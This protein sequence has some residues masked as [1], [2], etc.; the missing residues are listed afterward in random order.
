MRV[1]VTGATGFVGSN[2]ALALEDAGHDVVAIGSRG[3]QE[4]PEFRGKLLYRHGADLPLSEVG[5]VDILFHQGANADTSVKDRDQMFRDNLETSKVLF[6]Y[7]SSHGVKHIVYASSTAVYGNLPTPYKESGPIVPLNP[8]AE[9][10]AALD[11]YAMEFASEYPDIR[12]IGLRYC[13]VYGPR[14][15]HKGKMA[16][17]IRQLAMQMREGNPRIFK[18]GEQERE[19]IY[20]KDV[21]QA[22][23]LALNASESAVLNCSSGDPT[24]FNEL[25]RILNEV[26]GLERVPEYIDNPFEATYQNHI[27]CDISR[28]NSVI[29]FVPQFSVTAGIKDYLDSG[30]LLR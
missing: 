5:D 8:Y 3:E 2:L 7:A 28:I 14:E 18:W 4:L 1:L 9:S 17:M 22:N 25:T 26:M 30:F 27:A 6:A 12:V 23:M 21:V 13:N 11:E 10:K 24:S 29:G 20:V 15:S 19:H 16:S